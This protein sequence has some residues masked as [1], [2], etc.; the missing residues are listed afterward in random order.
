MTSVSVRRLISLIGAFVALMTAVAVPLGYGIVAYWKEAEILSFRAEL[1]AARA[2]S[3]FKA[4]G[5]I[6]TVPSVDLIDSLAVGSSHSS[7]IV[8]KIFDADNRVVAIAGSIISGPVLSRSAQIQGGGPHYAWVEAQVSLKPL[9]ASVLAV[10]L[11][12]ALAGLGIYWAFLAIPLRALDR[13]VGKLEQAR[14]E[15]VQ[16]NI[17]LD[18]AV[19]NM[20]QGLCMF[21]RHQ[22]VVVAN[23]RYAEIYGLSTDEVR[24]G[25]HVRQILEARLAKGIYGEVD[26]EAFVRD[27]LARFGQRVTIVHHLAD[28]RVVNSVRE[29]LPDGGLITTHEDITEQAKL[30]ELL[31][32]QNERLKEQEQKLQSQ[33]IQLD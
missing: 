24:P 20:V 16:Q 10:A 32:E 30:S 17:R 31:E 23:K 19:S 12:T 2:S 15:I 21:D 29:P 9:I 3:H 11:V 7:P 26:A 25:T 4:H 33:N 1:S 27:G 22:R 8:Q 14:A 6:W 5:G 28:G 13:M 18:L